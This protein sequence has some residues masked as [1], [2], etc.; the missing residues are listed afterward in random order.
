MNQAQDNP[1]IISTKRGRLGHIELNRPQAINALTA[2]M[3]G[4]M[5]R[6]LERWEVDPSISTVLL[7]GAGERGLC[8]GGDIVSIYNDARGRKRERSILA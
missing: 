5:A 4:E 3:V 1:A 7:T 8:A 6:V 2:E